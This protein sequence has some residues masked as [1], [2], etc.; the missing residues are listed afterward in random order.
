[1][2]CSMRDFSSYTL[3]LERAENATSPALGR[4]GAVLSFSLLVFVRQSGT[5]AKIYPSAPQIGAR[6]AQLRGYLF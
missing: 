3:S 2:P 6:C 4:S 5:Y 1:M